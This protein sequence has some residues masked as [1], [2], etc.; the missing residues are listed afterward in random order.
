MKLAT[1]MT[2]AEYAENRRRIARGLPPDYAENANG[3]QT[4]ES[5]ERDRELREQRR[6]ADLEEARR[7]VVARHGSPTPSKPGA[8]KNARDMSPQEY[9]EARDRIRRGLTT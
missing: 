4:A 3:T 9:A 1:E 8:P 5:V 6:Q 2:D 7:R